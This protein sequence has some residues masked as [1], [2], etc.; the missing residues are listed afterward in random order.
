VVAQL[1]VDYPNTQLLEYRLLKLCSTQSC[2][3]N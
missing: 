3:S 1:P 2:Y